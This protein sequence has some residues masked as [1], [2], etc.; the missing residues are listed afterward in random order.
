MR[1]HGQ[2][3][4]YPHPPDLIALSCLMAERRVAETRLPTAV[5][6]CLCK[7]GACA[8][9][10]DILIAAP[11]ALGPVVAGAAVAGGLEGA[12]DRRGEGTDPV[13]AAQP[14]GQVSVQV[15]EV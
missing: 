9:A 6:G 2:G 14:T 3:R 8:V 11:G 10:E 1:G 12:E 13:E 4:E 5:S 7:E 15:G